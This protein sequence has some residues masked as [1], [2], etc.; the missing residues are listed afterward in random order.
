[1]FDIKNFYKSC[2]F[3]N[4]NIRKKIILRMNNE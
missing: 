4:E 1:M 3:N 2:L